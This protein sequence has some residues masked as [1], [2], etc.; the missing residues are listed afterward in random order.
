MPHLSFLLMLMLLVASSASA[1]TGPP[2]PEVK[3][4]TVAITSIRDPD[5]KSFKRMKAGEE[6]FNRLHQ[7]A[8]NA[9]LYFILRPQQKGLSFSG[10]KIT[11]EIDDVSLPVPVDARGRFQ[12]PDVQR[13]NLEAAQLLLNKKKGLYRWRPDIHTPGIPA[14]ARRLG[15]LRLEC[16]VRWAVEADDLSF[17]DRNI[18][19]MAGGPC[20]ADFVK[21]IFPAPRAILQAKM[22]SANGKK[23]LLADVVDD[24]SLYYSV[25]LHDK[26][27]PDETL[28]EMEFMTTAAR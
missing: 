15:D 26:D 24:D 12:L 18:F 8:P 10:V 14:N 5:W 2:Q 22:V 9:P 28:V 25:P 3:F 16:E 1:E 6:A 13:E 20:H 27:W 17:M 21:V 19:R 4:S 7:L 11:V 23:S